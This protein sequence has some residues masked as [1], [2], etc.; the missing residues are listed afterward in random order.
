ML[1]LETFFRNF[2]FLRLTQA[3]KLADSDNLM[4]KTFSKET[5][6]DKT[7]LEKIIFLKNSRS[8]R[9]YSNE[10]LKVIPI[11]DSKM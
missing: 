3:C 2:F 5:Y 10:I 9:Q 7:N 4:T 8:N 6:L 11:K 1:R